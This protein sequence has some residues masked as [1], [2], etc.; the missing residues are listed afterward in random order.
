LTDFDGYLRH[1]ASERAL[2]PRTVDSYSRDVAQF[3]SFCEYLG[4]PEDHP[5]AITQSVLRKYLSSMQAK[6]AAQ[7]SISR[8]LSAVRSYMRYL[9][10]EERIAANPTALLHRAR[11][12][13]R[14]PRAAGVKD[15]DRLLS[16]A[17]GTSPLALRDRAILELL[18]SSGIRLAELVSLDVG[19][20]S[21]E[22]LSVRVM[23]KGGRERVAPVGRQAAVHLRNYLA[24]A[25]PQL[26]GPA[27]D[28]HAM[29]VN[30]TGTRLGGRSVE[31]MIKKYLRK[32]GLPTTMSPHSMRHSFATHMTDSGADLRSVQELMGHADISTTQIYTSVSKERLYRVYRDTHPRS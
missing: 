9:A 30:R 22:S 8:R 11:R 24:S 25:R 19:D 16:A 13:R 18:Y 29:F 31:R 21:E 32:A 6:G 2:S 23:G 12:P 7:S 27:N 15:V 10:R 3:L 17:G 1:L 14:L 4:I 26:L 28:C 5:E 20:Y